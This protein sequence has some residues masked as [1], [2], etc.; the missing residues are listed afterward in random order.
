[1]GARRAR[2]VPRM[3]AGSMCEEIADKY[4]FWGSKTL[5]MCG[6]RVNGVWRLWG[7]LGGE[8]SADPCR[9]EAHRGTAARP[10]VPRRSSD[11]RA[12]RRE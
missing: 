2:W 12:P 11:A 9:L 8:I 4:V 10:T 7:P 1:M 3:G 5:R 6:L